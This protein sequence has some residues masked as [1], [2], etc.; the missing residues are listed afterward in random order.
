M[1]THLHN[2]HCSSLGIAGPSV[3]C[4]VISGSSGTLISC[5]LSSPQGLPQHRS[6]EHVVATG[7]ALLGSVQM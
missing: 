3:C 4:V 5:R 7:L 1:F 2:R 6:W